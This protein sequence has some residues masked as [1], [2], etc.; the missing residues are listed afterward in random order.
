M[1]TNIDYRFSDDN[2][3]IDMTKCLALIDKDEKQLIGKGGQGSAYKVYSEKCGNLVIKAYNKQNSNWKQCLDKEYYYLSKVKNIVDDDIC[4]NFIYLYEKYND[5][6]LMEYADGDLKSF[7]KKIKYSDEILYSMIFQILMG[8]L[9]LQQILKIF[10]NDLARGNIFYKKI[11]TNKYKY[12]LYSINGQEYI[13]PN[14]GYLFMIGDFGHSN[15]LLNPLYNELN[16]NDVKLR[17]KQNHDFKSIVSIYNKTAV[18][19]LSSIFDSADEI[20]NKLNLKSNKSLLK[21]YEKHKQKINK[22]LI[23]ST[24]LAKNDSIKKRLLF[25]LIETNMINLLD[26]A[27]KFN[28]SLP[29]NNIKTL[30]K[31]V[32]S[33]NERIEKILNKYFNKYLYKNFISTNEIDKNNIKKFTIFF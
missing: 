11:P 4:P 12:F 10:H 19:N 18:E 16:I 6:L 22:S 31:N 29:S 32:F 27:N 14:C 17:I 21:Y 25:H 28:F 24:Q 2:K 9:V 13:L 15:N 8:I 20:I 30:L 3:L 33:S 7:L 23:N 5:L 26:C 1:E